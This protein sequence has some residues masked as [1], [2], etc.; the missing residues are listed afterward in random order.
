MAREMQTNSAINKRYR[1]HGVYDSQSATIG[2]H[3]ISLSDTSPE[4]SDQSAR[5]RGEVQI[6][7]DGKN[8]ATAHNIEIRPS[9]HDANRY[10]G[11]LVLVKVV[12]NQTRKEFL[13]LAQNVGV[14]SQV[15]R[16]PSGGYNFNYQRFRLISIDQQGVI[17]DETFFRR[18]RSDPVL[19]ARLASFVASSPMG[20]Y[21]D[22]LCGW[23]SLLFPVIF[24]WLS[25]LVGVLCIT[26]AFLRWLPS[27]IVRKT[28]L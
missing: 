10:W 11:F 1:F 8:Y 5:V 15:P 17:H 22:I 3:R 12:D 16:L 18:D 21:S 7:I 13:T 25:G 27:F 23:P 9:F 4:T 6:D 26:V 28:A 24:P 2:N 20:Y 14:D 19:R